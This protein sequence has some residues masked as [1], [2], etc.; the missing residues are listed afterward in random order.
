M[1]VL[2]LCVLVCVCVVCDSVQNLVATAAVD[3]SVCVWDLRNIRQAVSQLVGHTY[4]I[5]RV[6]VKSHTCA[7]THTLMCTP[8][9]IL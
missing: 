2:F 7:H 5:R 9:H 3:C 8:T 6:K 1:C 4:A